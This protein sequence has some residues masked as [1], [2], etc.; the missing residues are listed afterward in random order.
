VIITH[1]PE[2]Y[3]KLTKIFGR[4]PY[5]LA[6]GTFIYGGAIRD[7]LAGKEI[8]GDLDIATP[9]RNGIHRQVIKNISKIA[10]NW[11]PQNTIE[12][13]TSYGNNTPITSVINFENNKT[14]KLAQIIQAKRRSGIIP[15]TSALDI[16]ERVDIV[17]CGVA[18]DCWG[19]VYEVVPNAI[20]HC[21]HGIL[22]LNKANKQV[23]KDSE[24][25]RKR[26]Q[27]FLKRGWKEE[28]E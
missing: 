21:K 9:S 3:E 20:D 18:I 12:A 10:P 7:F 19:N 5:C 1:I 2:V 28:D 27:K 16:V 23:D 14:G 15:W 11:K 26:I 4:L 8:E 25:Y 24:Q 6:N 22:V 13:I 17:C